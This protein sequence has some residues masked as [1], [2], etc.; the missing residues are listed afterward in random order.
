[1]NI[2]LEI[3]PSTWGFANDLGKWVNQNIINLTVWEHCVSLCGNNDEHAHMFMVVVG[4]VC[5][6]RQKNTPGVNESI[7]T[8]GVGGIVCG[9]I[10]CCS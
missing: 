6:I 1:M 10:S 4:V 8:R 9:E 2:H 5:D 3:H 7:I